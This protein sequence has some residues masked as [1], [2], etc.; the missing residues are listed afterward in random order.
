MRAAGLLGLVAACAL[1]AAAGEY[2]FFPPVVVP[3]PAEATW[4][5][6]VCVRLAGGTARVRVDCPAALATTA[7]D[8]VARHFRAAF[9]FDC[10]LTIAADVPDT[11]DE[12]AYELSANAAGGVRIGAT[13]LA[14]VRHA[15]YTLRQI[16]I[17]DRVG[18]TSDKWIMPAFTVRD[19]PKLKFRGLHLCWF[20]EQRVAHI[21]RQIRLAAYYK[22]NVVVLENWGVYRSEKF[23]WFGWKDG[24][25][26]ATEIRRLKAI[27]DDLG[28]TLVPQLNVFGHASLSRVRT[29]N[30]ATLE[31]APEYEPLFEPYSGWNWC[32][33]NP[34]ARRVIRELAVELHTLFGNPPY[35]HIG[36]DE[37]C[38]PTC[39]TCRAADYDE[40]FS[41]LVRELADLMA[42][43]GASV[44]MWHD[45]LLVRGDHR[46]D[47]FYANGNER[48][49]RLLRSLPRSLIVCDWFYGD[50]QKAYPT[51]DYFGGEGFRVLTCPS[52]ANANGIVAQGRVAVEKGVFGFLQTNWS[53]CYG[54][55]MAAGFPRAACAAWGTT[56]G[57]TMLLQDMT[58]PV[59]HHLRQV[60]Q[61]MGNTDRTLTGFF[62]E[63]VPST[64]VTW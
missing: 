42:G 52:F 26:T 34:E 38:A 40:L 9:G 51:I 57:G 43:R 62:G 39:P 14:G 46:W 31:F 58:A 50:P 4:Q 33:S 3:T 56:W 44:M 5:T 18:M 54:R 21:E 1:S 63:Q 28:V 27:A 23:P 7:R 55:E 60:L 16:A 29:G 48:A 25:M 45:M 20:P 47:G 24:A 10:E 59:N 41:S 2:N 15:F 19:A 37:G 32:L 49:E 22:F 12:A 13:G 53:H 30:H 17:R 64:T 6:N 8:W 36:C 35:F 61:D 11:A